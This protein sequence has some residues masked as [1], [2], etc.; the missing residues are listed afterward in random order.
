MASAIGVVPAKWAR[1]RLKCWG[2]LA[3]TDAATGADLRLR[4]R[5]AR[6]LLAYLALHPGKPIS[7]ER[8]AGLLW[9]DRGEEQARASLRQALVEL[10]PLANGEISA[11]EVERDQ[12]SIRAG[13]LATDLDEIRA[14]AER[15][16]YP[17][18]LASLPEPDERLLGNLEGIDEAFDDW[19]TIERTR[20]REALLTLIADSSATALSQGQARHA[21]ALHVRLRELDPARASKP[22]DCA[23]ATAAEEGTASAAPALVHFGTARRARPLVAL[24]AVLLLAA[25]VA[26]VGAWQMARPG[27]APATIA[28]LPFKDLSASGNA[29]FAEGLSEEILAQLARE[30]GLRVAGR[31]SS[32]QFKDRTAGLE[33]VGRQLGVR[34]I[35]EGS[36]RTAGDRVRVNVALVQA[37]DGLQ[38]WAQ[39]FDGTLDDV[40]GIQQKIGVNVASA[41]GWKLAQAGPSSGGRT[42]SGQVYT[43]YL[44][45]RGLI[46]QRNPTA[47]AAAREKL[48]RA[49]AHDPNFAPAWSSL[50]QV[51]RF[52]ANVPGPAG[53]L[54][55][56][57]AVAQVRKALLLAPDLAEAHGVLGM[58]LGFDD[59]IGQKHIKRAA[60]LDPGN[61]EFQYWL[62]HVYANEQDFR[63]MLAAYDSA[64]TIDPLWHL[65][66]FY[67]VRSAWQLG[68]R[69]QAMS[70][71]GRIERDGSRYQAHFIRAALAGA[72]GDPSKEASEFAAASAS[73]RDPGK[74][75]VASY[76]RAFVLYGLGFFDEAG[77]EWSTVWNDAGTASLQVERLHPY[78]GYF[79]IRR[80]KL[81]SFAE[82][83]T[84][85]RDRMLDKNAEFA[86]LSAKLLINAG[87][88]REVV[89]LYDGEDGFLGLSRKQ[90]PERLRPHIVGGPI[91]ASA[92][93]AVGRE[94]EAHMITSRLHRLIESALA[95]SR[96]EAPAEFLA[97]AAQVW[98][99]QGE[100]DAAVSA[101]ER[102]RQHGWL[103]SSDPDT[104]LRDIGDE[105]AFGS[106]RGHPRFERF[107]AELRA[108]LARERVE[109]A[110]QLGRQE[111]IAR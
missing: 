7:R 109:L 99:M 52:E 38:L 26:A 35:L 103:Y 36:V 11:L 56:A 69:Q 110:R 73:T 64:F 34:Y 70:Y 107:R 93:R 40:L 18:L 85:N 27:P 87:R 84:Y 16:D 75:A 10:K 8:L 92:L 3:I 55:L 46:R 97:A 58:T 95:R 14:A 96:G 48:A 21:R 5:K 79:A 60:A 20:Q 78:Q 100:D 51:T 62:G 9:G 77:R 106:L 67:A 68:R 42:T 86:A 66:Q 47:M 4:G 72:K 91:A 45:A 53:A 15:G 54:K 28:V 57:E 59:P 41:L 1:V 22:S 90:P 61:A 71:V 108:H 98:A 33:E 43:L 104:S 32:W 37:S 23:P 111:E 102:A 13:A 82:L 105:P 74:K 49:L 44:S 65:A 88:A 83:Q 80:G 29:F 24:L 12:V 76:N 101:L 94:A 2:D 81:P 50:A 30:P 89:S 31:T 25:L 63:R 39:S 19:L 17:A 6:A